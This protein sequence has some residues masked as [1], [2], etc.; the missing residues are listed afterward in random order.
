MTVSCS[1]VSR[2]DTPPSAGFPSLAVY[3]M[4]NL[5]NSERGNTLVAYWQAALGKQL[6]SIKQSN[7]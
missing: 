5:I 4:T 7:P 1:D 2:A 6:Q 3:P